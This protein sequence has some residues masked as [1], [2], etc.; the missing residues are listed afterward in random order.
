MVEEAAGGGHDD[1]RTG[2]QG[3]H[4]RVEA[5]AAVDG[6]GADRALGAVRPDA[7]FD[8]ESQL[9]GRGED[10]AANRQAGR[11]IAAIG[12]AARIPGGGT[13]GGPRG[14]QTLE[15]RQDEGGGLAGPG[16]G[17]GQHVAAGQHE[18]N[19]LGLHGG[20]LGVALRGD[21]AEKLG[22]KPELIE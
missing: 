15:E 7:L 19:R 4:L 9:A 5:D 11:G 17:A 10:E 21:R 16:L 6:G 13:A 12:S 22:L 14:V 18:R 3:A 1:L 20:G 8:L 2:A